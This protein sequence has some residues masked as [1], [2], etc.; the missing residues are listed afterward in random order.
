MFSY[1]NNN[2]KLIIA[3]NFEGINIA[4]IDPN[5]IF[6]EGSTWVD[7]KLLYETIKAY[8]ALSGWKPTLES[9]T[10]I[11]CLCFAQSRRKNCSTCECTNGSLSKD[12]KWQIRIKSSRNINRKILSGNL[13][14]K[15]KSIPLVDDGVPVII[16]TSNC[17]HTDSCK[18]SLQQQLIQHARS[19]EYIKC[20][21]DIALFILCTIY[22]EK[23]SLKSYYIKSILQ[24]QF[25]TN[26]N[27][28]KFHVFNMKKES[29]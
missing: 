13:E 10:C 14:G 12:Y 2:P 17:Q 7:R 5:E 1:D 4:N 18:S 22:T 16:S 26:Q 29:K 19:G 25:P 8:A 11:K 9:R 28:T 3:C 20:I 27:V 21:S 6:Y 23:N 24:L 15:F